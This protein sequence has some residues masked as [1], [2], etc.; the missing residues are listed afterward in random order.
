[1][2]REFRVVD[3]RST[4]REFADTYVLEDSHPAMYYASSDGRYRGLVSIDDLRRIE[5]SQWDVDT[6]SDIAHPLAEIPS[7]PESASLAT[8]ILDLEDQSLRRIT[9]LSPAG[10]VAGII[11]RG[12]IIRVVA[13]RLGIPF[14]GALVR[15][16]KEEGTYPPEL[17]LPAI[18]R[19][20]YPPVAKPVA[21]PESALVD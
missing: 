11:D 8:V 16:I 10:A 13:Q 6:L 1:M 4:L 2:T 18:A 15:R 5:R 21:H 17:Q 20:I 12:D 14:A 19:A 7:V 3:A 9:V